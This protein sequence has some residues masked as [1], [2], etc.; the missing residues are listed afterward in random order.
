MSRNVLKMVKAS[1]VRYLEG[2]SLVREDG[3]MR[4]RLMVGEVNWGVM[5]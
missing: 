2:R 3:G 1:R 5:C 4:N